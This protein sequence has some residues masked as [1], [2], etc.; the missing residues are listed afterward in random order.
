[1]LRQGDVVLRLE[2]NQKRTTTAAELLERFPRLRSDGGVDDRLAL[3][4]AERP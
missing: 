3:S 1:M 2:G 4:L